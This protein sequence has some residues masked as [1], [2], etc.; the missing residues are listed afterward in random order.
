VSRTHVDRTA[1]RAD[2]T[3]QLLQVVPHVRVHTTIANR[4]Y[5]HTS[6]EGDVGGY[7]GDIS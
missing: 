6:E 5:S 3:M 1:T 7:T 2:C 4:P